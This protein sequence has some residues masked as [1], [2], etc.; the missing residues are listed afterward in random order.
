VARRRGFLLAGAVGAG[1]VLLVLGRP[2]GDPAGPAGP[3]GGPAADPPPAAGVAAPAVPAPGS[4]P[5]PASPSPVPS[6]QDGGVAGAETLDPAR[7]PAALRAAEAF[8]AAWAAPDPGWHARLAGLTTPE[9][10]AALARADP[11]QPAPELTGTGQLHYGAPR[12]ARIGVP[13]VRGTVVLDLVEVDGR[14]LVSAID[15]WPA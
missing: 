5:G 10:A 12:W 15:W 11:P 13:A 14:W 8:A 2:G 1:V 3:D 6:V 4:A 9:L 7:R